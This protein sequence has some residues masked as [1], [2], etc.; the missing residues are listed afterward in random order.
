MCGGPLKSTGPCPTEDS[1]PRPAGLRAGSNLAS[2]ALRVPRPRS[3]H[4]ER[5]EPR[6][7]PPSPARQAELVLEVSL[8]QTE[9]VLVTT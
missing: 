3:V 6:G 1:P 7:L 2:Q 8:H 4:C 5:R 9:A